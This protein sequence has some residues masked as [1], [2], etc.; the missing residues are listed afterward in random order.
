M[1]FKNPNKLKKK[2]KPGEK[3]KGQLK[4]SSENGTEKKPKQ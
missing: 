4:T 1:S 3:S 2:R